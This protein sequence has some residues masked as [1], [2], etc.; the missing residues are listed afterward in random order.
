MKNQYHFFEMRQ[1]GKYLVAALVCIAL[2]GY[3]HAQSSGTYGPCRQLCKGLSLNCGKTCKVDDLAAIDEACFRTNTNGIEDLPEEQKVPKLSK[4]LDLCNKPGAVQAEKTPKKW[5]IKGR[6][7]KKLVYGPCR[8]R[9]TQLNL[10]KCSAIC[11][12]NPGDTIDVPC[13]KQC[14]AAVQVRNGQRGLPNCLR[15]CKTRGIRPV[16]CGTATN[17]CCRWGIWS[18]WVKEP[19][20]RTCGGGTIRQTRR[21]VKLFGSIGEPQCQGKAFE[22]FSG[23]CNTQRCIVTCPPL[24]DPANGKVDV[25]CYD[26]GCIATVTCDEG[27]KPDPRHASKVKCKRNGKWN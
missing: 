7:G 18:Q 26:P 27:Y 3:V 15:Q 25:P 2:A 4:I 14:A 10:R 24:T 13:F 19:C 1:Q 21:R 6:G 11:K 23:V 17:P 5:R 8:I 22:V 12:L 20:T 9:C 16:R